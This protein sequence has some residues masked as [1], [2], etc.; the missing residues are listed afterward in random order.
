MGGDAVTV[1]SS[2]GYT[3]L[4]N[5]NRTWRNNKRYLACLSFLLSTLCYFLYIRIIILNAWIA[6]LLI[7]SSTNGFDGSMMNGL[8]SLPQWQDAFNHPGSAMLGLL[9]AIQSIGA[10]VGLPFS[11][12]VADGFGRRAAVLYGAGIMVRLTLPPKRLTM[13]FNRLSLLPS[14]LPHKVLACSL[15]LGF[16][17]VS[18]SPSPVVA[19]PC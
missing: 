4:L 6:L 14:K 2:T 7:T 17:S 15:A 19:P 3:H 16:S 18:D 8:Q 11:P 13:D 1:D 12:Y 5:P 9:N 10:L